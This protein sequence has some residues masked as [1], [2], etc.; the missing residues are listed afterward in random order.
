MEIICPNPPPPLPNLIAKE[1]LSFVITFLIQARKQL[2]RVRRCTFDAQ[3]AR[4]FDT[5]TLV[6]CS[7]SYIQPRVEKL[8]AG[9]PALCVLRERLPP[10]PFREILVICGIH[11]ITSAVGL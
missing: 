9:I 10:K 6:H 11:C 7:S 2:S 5:E 3:T 1:L 8:P 4:A